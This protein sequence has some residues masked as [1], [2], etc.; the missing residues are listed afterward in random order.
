[1]EFFF[2]E[3]RT[4][5]ITSSGFSGTIEAE[6]TLV[7]W[8]SGL[9]DMFCR[10]RD[11]RTGFKDWPGASSDDWVSDSSASVASVMSQFLYN[12]WQTSAHCKHAPAAK[13]MA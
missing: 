12:K 2:L 8:S 4:S 7:R 1:M 5:E 9:L 3:T 13:K 10:P 6:Q 11:R